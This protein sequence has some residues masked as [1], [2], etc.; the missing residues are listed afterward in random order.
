MRQCGRA[1]R[2]SRPWPYMALIR[3][4]TWRAAGSW[5]RRDTGRW[6]SPPRFAARA[7][8]RRPPRCG[9]APWWTT[10]RRTGW[11]NVRRGRRLR[12]CSWTM[13]KRSGPSFG[14]ALIRGCAA[15]S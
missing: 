14:T 3:H 13:P 9:I 6:Q 4:L 7:A 8:R 11:P 15:S 2:G 5:Q 10:S 12:L 1:M